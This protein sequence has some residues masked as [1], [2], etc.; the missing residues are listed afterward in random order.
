[1][2]PRQKEKDREYAFQKAPDA[3]PSPRGLGNAVRL[4]QHEAGKFAASMGP[5]EEH[6]KAKRMA[7][8]STGTTAR[9]RRLSASS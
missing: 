9:Q 5:E 4:R 6:L 3:Q 7:P 8:G 2:K 1:M